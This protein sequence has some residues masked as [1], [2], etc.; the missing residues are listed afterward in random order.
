[1]PLF[2]FVSSIAL[3]VGIYVG[4]NER[5]EVNEEEKRRLKKEE[6]GR[7]DEKDEGQKEEEREKGG[8]VDVE[9]R[10]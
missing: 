9:R 10:G 4:W 7:E 3:Y 1:M 8:Q 2:L 5:K 6:E